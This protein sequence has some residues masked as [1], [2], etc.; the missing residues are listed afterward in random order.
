MKDIGNHSTSAGNT[1]PMKTNQPTERLPRTLFLLVFV[2]LTAG[3]VT[4]GVFAY[5]HY[6]RQYRTEVERQLSAIAALKVSELAQWRKERM[7]DGDTLF[8]NAAISDLVRRLL[9][10]P[11]DADAPRQL[12][13]WFG[14]YA[15][16]FRYDHIRLLD[17]QGVTRLSWPA[18]LSAVAPLV[19]EHAAEA[20][21][22]GQVMFQDFYRSAYDQKVY[23]AL[24][25]P[26]LDERD[27]R[28]PLGA[29]VLRIDPQHY[30]Y[31]FIKR[32]PTLSPTAETLL[33]RRDGHDAL[34][35]NELRF[36]TNSALTLRVSLD[37]VTMPA[38]QA[39]LGKEILMQG[40]DYRGVPVV[41]A[42]RTIP[43]SPW[44]LV[45]RLDAAEVYGP[46]RVQLWRLAVTIGLLLL[47][48]WAVAGLLWRQ[49]HVRFYREQYRMSEAMR[50]SEVR[51]RR[52]FEAA[53][54]GILIL[55]AETGMVADVNP[56]LVEL[57]GVTR[58][59]FLGKKVWELGFFKDLVANEAKFVE[60]QQK[61]Y[62]RYE[63]MA[64]EGHDG[65]RHEVEF[66]SNVYLVNHQKVIQCNI[67]DISDRVKAAAAIRK[68]NTELEQRV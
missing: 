48:A 46:L 14:K 7:A 39:A 11:E 13:I 1:A 17:T 4:I 20:C 23:L 61:N 47:T 67:R 62:I 44:A 12:Q 41:A 8:Q 10:K 45:A 52:L 60:L 59:V 53:K 35:L 9:E 2:L 33:V 24:L 66:V 6:E 30:L 32:W 25:I 26:M 55:D 54:D 37:E 63:N 65:T 3:I 38:V 31:P 58:E 16:H 51:Y 22:S 42:T 29:L 43:D 56:F 5:R 34:F 57:L 68:L 49:Q 18:G 64:L 15:A 21:R 40:V 36:Q 19:A 28:R 27:G 50:A